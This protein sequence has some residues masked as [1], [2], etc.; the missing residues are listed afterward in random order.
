MLAGEDIRGILSLDDLN[1]PD[2]L[3]ICVMH[4]R[5][6][7]DIYAGKDWGEALYNP[8]KFFDVGLVE[9]QL[10]EEMAIEAVTRNCYAYSHLPDRFKKSDDIQKIAL[11][12]WQAL[13]I[14]PKTPEL[15]LMAV[16]ADLKALPFVPGHV[17][18]ELKRAFDFQNA[19]R[20]PCK[21]FLWGAT[22][23]DISKDSATRRARII[24]IPLQKLNHHGVHHSKRFKKLIL[25]FLGIEYCIH[26]FVGKVISALP[27]AIEIAAEHEIISVYDSD[28]E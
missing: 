24:T 5:I 10:T 18:R 27:M 7:G 1:D 15:C 25:S 21:A 3:A 6:P 26:A 9:K 19:L 12:H 20:R 14:L 11:L 17:R 8:L 13:K 22:C 4:S 23:L 2:M 16:E 28:D